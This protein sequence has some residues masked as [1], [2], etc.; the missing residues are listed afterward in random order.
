MILCLDEADF[1]NA[2]LSHVMHGKTSAKPGES[3]GN[4]TFTG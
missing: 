2:C 4:N 1:G 3:R